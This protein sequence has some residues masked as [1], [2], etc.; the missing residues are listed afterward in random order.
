MSNPSTLWEMTNDCWS[1]L[2]AAKRANVSRVAKVA[3]IKGSGK[4]VVYL[5]FGRMLREW[6]IKL[7]S[8]GPDPSG[9][10]DA[11]D[12]MK[13]DYDTLLARRN[14]ASHYDLLLNAVRP[15]LSSSDV[16]R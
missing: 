7:A 10:G 4:M 12:V 14:M 3:K 16:R 6:R 9:V 2:S 8:Y 13:W 5:L 1:S 11:G 15:G